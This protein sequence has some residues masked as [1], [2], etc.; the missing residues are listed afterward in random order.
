MNFTGEN[1]QS[2]TTM[3]DNIAAINDLFERKEGPQYADGYTYFCN[4][5]GLE[6]NVGEASFDCRGGRILPVYIKCRYGCG[7]SWHLQVYP[8]GE[9]CIHWGPYRRPSD[10]LTEQ[11]SS[12]IKQRESGHDLHWARKHWWIDHQGQDD[13]GD[14][15]TFYRSC[16]RVP[17]GICFCRPHS[18]SC[19]WQSS[20]G[21]P[22]KLRRMG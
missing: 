10:N 4:N 11:W 6:C 14:D 3:V 19:N 16:P 22:E 5:C 9:A 8:S 20:G 1:I 18:G 13:W 7:R 17:A 21:Q 15:G 12:P 2:A